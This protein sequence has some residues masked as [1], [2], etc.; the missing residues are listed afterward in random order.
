MR[1]FLSQTIILLDKDNSV[2]VL[3]CK[4]IQVLKKISTPRFARVVFFPKT[5]PD[6]TRN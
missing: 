5:L 6:K 2:S 1:L 3:S 4:V